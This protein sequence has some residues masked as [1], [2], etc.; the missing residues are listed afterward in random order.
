MSN[1]DELMTGI[2]TAIAAADKLVADEELR[3]AEEEDSEDARR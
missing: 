2:N 3:N 1:R